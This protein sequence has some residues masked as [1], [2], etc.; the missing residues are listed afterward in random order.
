MSKLF[1]FF[2][3]LN[4]RTLVIMACACSG[5]CCPDFFK[6]G[7][8]SNIEMDRSPCFLLLGILKPFM[9]LLGHVDTCLDNCSAMACLNF[10]MGDLSKS[11]KD[12]NNWN[13]IFFS[14]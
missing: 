12:K 10:N 5:S 7:S 3:F 8:K 6:E 2:S 4:G 9:I 13:L 14:A 1:F 11:I